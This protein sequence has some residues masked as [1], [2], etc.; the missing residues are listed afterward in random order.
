MRDER[1][2]ERHNH[3]GYISRGGVSLDIF[4]P[5]ADLPLADFFLQ[6]RKGTGGGA[7]RIGVKLRIDNFNITHCNQI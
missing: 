7:E 5:E 4:P 2:P 6:K 1:T 3:A